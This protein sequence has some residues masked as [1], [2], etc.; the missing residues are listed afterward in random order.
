MKYIHIKLK[1]VNEDFVSSYDDDIDQSEEQL[2]DILYSHGVQFAFEEVGNL[3]N[4]ML[5]DLNEMHTNFRNLY[6][7]NDK[8]YSFLNANLNNI[9]HDCSVEF[10]RI[11][12]YFIDAVSNSDNPLRYIKDHTDIYSFDV[13]SIQSSSSSI[14]IPGGKGYSLFTEKLIGNSFR[15]A[16]VA[17]F[18]VC[19]KDFVRLVD[20]EKALNSL[21]NKYSIYKTILNELDSIYDKDNVYLSSSNNSHSYDQTFLKRASKSDENYL[22][23]IT[24]KTLLIFFRLWIFSFIFERVYNIYDSAIYTMHDMPDVVESSIV[25][26]LIAKIFTCSHK[27]IDYLTK[28]IPVY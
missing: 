18:K 23:S 26:D 11:Q 5:D 20:F 22:N 6:D 17:G 4:D 19:N 14:G 9:I 24:P 13:M 8:F 15:G 3:L 21:S 2:D 7:I 10:N 16:I 1:N 25:M 12:T 27:L 28:T